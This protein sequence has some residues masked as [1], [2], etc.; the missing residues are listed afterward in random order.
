MKKI[1]KIQFIVLLCGT[2]FAWGNFIKE[3]FDWMNKRACTTGCAVGLVNPFFTACFY[4][5]IFFTIAFILNIII[6][7]KSQK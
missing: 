5:A 4:G 7:K 3:L 6:L 1:I 2:L